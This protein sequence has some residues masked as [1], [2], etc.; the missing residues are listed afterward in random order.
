MPVLWHEQSTSH[1]FGKLGQWI[2]AIVLSLDPIIVTGVALPGFG[3]FMAAVKILD[4]FDSKATSTLILGYICAL[5]V[6][7]GVYGAWFGLYYYNLKRIRPE[8]QIP[9]NFFMIISMLI[10]MFYPMVVTTIG[11]NPVHGTTGML[12]LMI[13]PILVLAV[14]WIVFT[15]IA[16][17]FPRA[18]NLL[19]MWGLI[20]LS[21]FGLIAK[22]Y[23]I[24]LKS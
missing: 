18:A 13:K 7:L 3:S 11:T 20:I 8:L 5:G 19:A 1:S 10:G 22:A 16:I 2:G 24:Y 14:A 23:S 17:R 21:V 12:A 9:R 6:F 4:A 15:Q